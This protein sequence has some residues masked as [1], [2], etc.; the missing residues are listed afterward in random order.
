MAPS[1]LERL[2][3]KKPVDR[4]VADS[5]ASADA[6]GSLGR[7]I[8]QFQLVTF[9]VGATIGIGIFFV[10]SQQVP[11]ASPAVIISFIIA[12][13]VAGLAALCYAEMSSMTPVFGSSYSHD[14]ATLGDGVAFFVAA[15]L[16]L[17]YGV[18]ASAAAAGWS[19][20]VHKLIAKMTGI[21]FASWLTQAPITAEPNNVYSLSFSG[22]GALPA[23]ILVFLCCMFLLRGS[24]ESARAYAVLALVKLSVLTQLH[25]TAFELIAAWLRRRRPDAGSASVPHFSGSSTSASLA[26]CSADPAQLLGVPPRLISL[27]VRDKQMCPIG[28]SYDTENVVSNA[29][30]EQALEAQTVL[31]EHWESPVSVCGEIGDGRMWKAV[32]DSLLWA[33][34]ELL[35]AGASSLGPL[36]WV[37]LGSNSNKIAHNSPVPCLI[38]PRVED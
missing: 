7:S 29:P 14:L 5:Q 16:I 30:R 23:I 36:L 35:V 3:R 26:R 18:S 37:F 12:A 19:E 8:T 20:Y 38:M 21:T 22:E 10:L 31:I 17:E 4:L 24:K 32:L 27:V 25:L 2:A 33:H 6:L 15:C 1:L 11:T 13:I 9:G 28:A 34:T